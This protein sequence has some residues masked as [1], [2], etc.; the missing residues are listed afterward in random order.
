MEKKCPYSDKC[1]DD[2]CDSCANNEKKSYYRPESY[3]YPYCQPFFP[4]QWTWTIPSIPIGNGTITGTY[5]T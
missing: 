5:N 1:S 2:R 4:I 3:Y